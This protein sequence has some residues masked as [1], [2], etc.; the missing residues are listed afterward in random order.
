MSSKHDQNWVRITEVRLQQIQD[1]RDALLKAC[2][3]LVELY[4]A[5]KG[6]KHEFIKCVTP[7]SGYKLTQK[8]RASCKFWAAWDAA[9]D[10]IGAAKK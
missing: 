1:E 4:V 5:N 3:V 10:A 2:E 8:Q 6:S 7:K 9:R